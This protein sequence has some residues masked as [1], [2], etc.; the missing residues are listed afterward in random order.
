[1]QISAGAQRGRECHILPGPGAP[2]GWNLLPWWDWESSL[3]LL[4]NPY[5]LVTAEP[6]LQSN[7]LKTDKRSLVTNYRKMPQLE[8]LQQSLGPGALVP[9]CLVSPSSSTASSQQPAGAPRSPRRAV[10]SCLDTEQRC[11][12]SPSGILVNNGITV[13]QG[14]CRDPNTKGNCLSQVSSASHYKIL[15]HIGRFLPTMSNAD[16]SNP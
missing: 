11:S 6:S 5:M 10:V 16:L 4:K 7:R 2:G 12:T 8:K 14:R 15:R 13:P 1:M 3:D 9:M